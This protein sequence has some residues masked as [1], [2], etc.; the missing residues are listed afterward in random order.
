MLSFFYFNVFFYFV[1][2]SININQNNIK[3]N[4]FELPVTV[5]FSLKISVLI[6]P[7]WLYILGISYFI[8]Y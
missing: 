4:K 3:T 2:V 1:H 6:A 8:P 5:V 7:V